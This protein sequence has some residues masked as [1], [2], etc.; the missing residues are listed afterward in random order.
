MLDLGGV[1]DEW[2]GTEPGCLGLGSRGK[3][4]TRQRKNDGWVRDNERQ[5]MKDKAN[6]TQIAISQP[7]RIGRPGR[8][9]D[10]LYISPYF[11][12]THILP[13]RARSQEPWQAL[14]LVSPK[15]PPT[16]L[17]WIPWSAVNDPRGPTACL[18]T[19]THRI[20]VHIHG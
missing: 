18:L 8:E 1:Q 7:G 2:M 13:Y 5:A 17:R 16:V 12:R 15:T 10:R 19:S 11:H 20:H 4:D 3:E 14:Q 6:R 9:E